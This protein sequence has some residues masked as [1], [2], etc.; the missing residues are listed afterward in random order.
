M[1]INSRPDP[2]HLQHL[3]I[4]PDGHTWYRYIGHLDHD[5]MRTL[6]RDFASGQRTPDVRKLPAR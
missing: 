3:L 5:A 6:V 2:V 1:S 4:G